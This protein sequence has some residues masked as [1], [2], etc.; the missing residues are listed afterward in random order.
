M[1]SRAMGLGRFEFS[2]IDTPSTS[3]IFSHEKARKGP[4]LRKYL[5][6]AYR[7][8]GVSSRSTRKFLRPQF[9]W[10]KFRA[11]RANAGGEF[12]R[13]RL[14]VTPCPN[15]E[16]RNSRPCCSLA[17]N[18]VAVLT[19]SNTE[20]K[21]DLADSQMR[22]KKMKRNSRSRRTGF[23]EPARPSRK[24]AGDRFFRSAFRAEARSR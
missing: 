6:C 15:P 18:A 7:R 3:D 23:Q 4:G 19:V 21:S 11:R 13:S 5:H 22:N 24:T 10:Q 9:L 16:S 1:R 14:W 2:E 20:L 8:V 17:N 12:V